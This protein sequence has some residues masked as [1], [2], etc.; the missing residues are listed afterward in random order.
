[1]ELNPKKDKK[2]KNERA[3]HI[4][5]DSSESHSDIS[6]CSETVSE[7]FSDND[8]CITKSFEAKN[9]VIVEYDSQYFPGQVEEIR[10]VSNGKEYLVSTM[11]RSGP[12]GWRWPDKREDKIWYSEE[13]VLQKIASP[14]VTNSRGVCNVAEMQKYSK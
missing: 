13:R 12:S 5:T 4:D 10:E 8:D 11:L 1:M 6:F 14:S 7:T 2:R 9:Y 3:R